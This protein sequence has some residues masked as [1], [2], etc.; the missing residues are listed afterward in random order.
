M[1]PK[2]R[3]IWASELGLGF[4]IDEGVMAVASRLE[5]FESSLTVKASFDSHC[6]T[7]NV[8]RNRR[9]YFQTANLSNL[10]LN[11]QPNFRITDRRGTLEIFRT[12]KLSVSV[13]EIFN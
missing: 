12:N 10:G 3:P 6:S 1:D 9:M 8:P 13:F 7:S 4:S 11:E 2:R 5:I